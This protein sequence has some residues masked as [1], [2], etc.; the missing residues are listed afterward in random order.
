[1]PIGLRKYLMELQAE[2]ASD[3]GDDAG[4]GPGDSGA[5]GADDGGSGTTSA[6]VDFDLS[7]PFKR[8][9]L[10]DEAA[11]N[12]VEEPSGLTCVTAEIDK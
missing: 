9:R 6:A 5:E 10:E 7:D 2:D 3:T 11:D 12:G 1:M 8:C 4:A